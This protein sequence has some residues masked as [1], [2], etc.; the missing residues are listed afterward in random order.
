VHSKLADSAS[1][2]TSFAVTSYAFPTSN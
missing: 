2:K 1:L